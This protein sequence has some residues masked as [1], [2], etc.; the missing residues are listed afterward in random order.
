MRE[1][2]KISAF[3]FENDLIN[4]SEYKFTEAEAENFVKIGKRFFDCKKLIIYDLKMQ[5]LEI[6]GRFD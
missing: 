3:R 2:C 6:S 4:V 5:C 1:F